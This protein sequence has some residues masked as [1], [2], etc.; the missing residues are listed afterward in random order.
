MVKPFYVLLTQVSAT[1]SGYL[2]SQMMYN[3]LDVTLQQGV[4][5]DAVLLPE[6]EVSSLSSLFPRLPPQAAQERYLSSYS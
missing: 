1:P 4:Q 5:G 6:R 3:K 2:N